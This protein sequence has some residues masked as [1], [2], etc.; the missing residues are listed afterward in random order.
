MIESGRPD[1]L[2]NFSSHAQSL[3]A[4]LETDFWST[5]TIV[6]D[7]HQY[8]RSYFRFHG[9]YAVIP[10]FIPIYQDAVQ[11]ETYVKTLWSQYKQLRRWAW[12]CSDIPFVLEQMRLQRKYI[13]F[14]NRVVNFYRLM[15]GHYMWATAAIIITLTVPV[16]RMINAHFAQTIISYNMGVTLSNFFLIAMVGIFVSIWVSLLMA[17]PIPKENKKRFWWL[18]ITSIF[19][20]FFLPITTVIFGSLPAIEAQTRLML[21]NSLDFQVTEKIR[22]PSSP[23]ETTTPI[24]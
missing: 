20:W 19:Q 1:R 6:E 21:G 4:L 22:N 8:W 7:G 10:L 24:H 14:W 2:R 17:P 23:H 11:H 16:P 9:N 5:T 15:E 18:R 3:D 12:G 13:P